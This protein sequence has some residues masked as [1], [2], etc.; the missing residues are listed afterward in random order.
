[1]NKSQLSNSIVDFLMSF[2]DDATDKQAIFSKF[3]NICGK[4]G[5]YDVPDELF[6]KRTSR[7]NRVL[8]PWQT[9]KSNKLTID[10]LEKFEGGVAVEF[11]NKDYFEEMRQTEE[12]PIFSILKNR[13]GSDDTVSAII[14]IRS[15]GGSASSSVQREAYEL[16]K[17]YFPD[18]QNHLFKTQNGCPLFRERQ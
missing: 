1:M 15:Q 18:Y 5:Q 7:S 17:Q 16:M 6:Q 11:V 13:L 4:T 10:D 8:I 12:N 14:S 2:F 9:V 3:K